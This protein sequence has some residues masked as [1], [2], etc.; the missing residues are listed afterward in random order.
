[1]KALYPGSFDPVTLGHIDIIRRAAAIFGG[2]TVG[3][4]A[5]PSKRP[6]FSDEA[7]AAMLREACGDVE[8]LEIICFDG[9]L[10][11][12]VNEKGFDVVV[13]GLRGQSDSDPEIQM[14]QINAKLYNSK[15]E[16]VFLATSPEYSWISSS[17]VREVFS[18][19]GDVSAMVAAETL[20]TMSD[21]K[22]G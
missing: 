12:L 15:V 18:L 19:G 17:A 11:D 21:I 10:A 2:L 6:M 14:A 8:G 20:K 7:R 13:R 5:N 4:V 16:T 3:V 1:M 22:R 9:L